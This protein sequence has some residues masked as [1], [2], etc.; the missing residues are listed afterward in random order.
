MLTEDFVYIQLELEDCSDGFWRNPLKDYFFDFIHKGKI[1][2][3]W[4]N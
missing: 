4:L 1:K 2:F 3:S